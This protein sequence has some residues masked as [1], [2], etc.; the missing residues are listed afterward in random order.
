MLIRENGGELPARIIRG[1]VE[2]RP[3][4]V[5]KHVRNGGDNQVKNGHAAA[6]SDVPFAFFLSSW[7]KRRLSLAILFL[8]AG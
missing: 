8:G 3:G 6:Q 5:H 4:M 2:L 7:E 1:G